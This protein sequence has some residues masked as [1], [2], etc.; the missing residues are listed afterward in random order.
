MDTD[1][2]YLWVH[3]IWVVFRPWFRSGFVDGKVI[4]EK[5]VFVVLA[6]N[7]EFRPQFLSFLG[8]ISSRL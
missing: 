3:C 5:D 2:V 1:R 7:F 4:V 8:L 6:A